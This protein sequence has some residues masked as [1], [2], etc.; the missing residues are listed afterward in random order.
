MSA[1]ETATWLGH[2]FKGC[3]IK[4]CD[5]LQCHHGGMPHTSSPYLCL[6]PVEAHGPRPAE[7]ETPAA[8]RTPYP[9][10]HQPNVCRGR[11][12]CPRGPNCGE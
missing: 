9:W 12:S 3:D 1:T 2:P 7:P 8:E 11:G 6:K 4:W 10:C 5:Q